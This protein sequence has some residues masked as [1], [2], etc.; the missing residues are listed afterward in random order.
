M[1]VLIGAGMF[2]SLLVVLILGVPIAYS[3]LF[4]GIGALLILSGDFSSLSIVANT[5]WSSVT[6]VTLTSL[7]IFLLMGSI[8]SASG[9]GARLYNSLSILLYGVP[10][11]LG[12]ATTLACTVMA[13]VSGSS[14]A[15]VADVM[16][17]AAPLRV[18]NMTLG[19]AIAGPFNR[20]E[21]NAE[22]ISGK[23][24]AC[25]KNLEQRNGDI[26]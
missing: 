2:V 7:P 6:S 3:L 22:S 13:T 25:I 19:V 12:V 11:G 16:A 4:V 15:N 21:Q 18:G 17:I 14:V 26:S 10:G 1:E 5:Y 23:L 8:I 24:L 9:M 20:M